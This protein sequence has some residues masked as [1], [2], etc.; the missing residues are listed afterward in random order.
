MKNNLFKFLGM[1]VLTL[2]MFTFQSCDT[3]A[4]KDVDCG[5]TGTCFEGVCICDAGYETDAS[6]ACTVLTRAQFIGNYSVTETCVGV[7]DPYTYTT[8]IL[9]GSS[10]DRILIRN[11]GGYDCIDENGNSINYDV[12]ATVSEGGTLEFIDTE[13][14]TSFTGTGSISEANGIT[15]LVI[16]YL[17]EYSDG[18][19]PPNLITDDCTATMTK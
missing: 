5:A 15:T 8:E 14:S 10:A 6:G 4:C 2:G 12:E 3:D 18:A 19:T 1:I 17:A 11:L 9:A 13:C 16:S 7:A